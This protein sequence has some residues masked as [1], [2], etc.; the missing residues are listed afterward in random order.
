MRLLLIRRIL[1]GRICML[2]LGC[3]IVLRRMSRLVIRVLLLSVLV[4]RS[5]VVVIRC[6]CWVGVG[7]VGLLFGRRVLLVCLL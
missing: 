6:W 7:M 2:M 1:V 5:D 3:G 4:R